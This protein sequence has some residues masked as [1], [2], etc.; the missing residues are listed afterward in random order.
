MNLNKLTKVELI[1]KIDQLKKEKLDIK[2]N[3]ANKIND[4][5]ITVDNKSTLIYDIFSKIKTLILSLSIIGILSQVFKNYK[6]IR[7]I[8]RAA[9]YIIIGLFGMSLFDAFG[10]GFIVKFLGELKYV[11]GSI[12]TYLT[13]STFYKYMLNMFNVAEE[14]EKESVRGTYKKSEKID[15]KAELEKAEREREREKWHA[16]YKKHNEEGIDK[17]TI[18]LLLLFLGGSIGVWY[19]GKDGL[20][21]IWGGQT[22]SSLISK[23]VRGWRPGDDDE[24]DDNNNYL[25]HYNKSVEKRDIELDPSVRSESP[26]MMETYASDMIHPKL[27]EHLPPVAPPMPPVASSSNVENT[28]IEEQPAQPRSLLESIK[29]GKSLKKTKIRE[30]S[31]DIR[32]GKEV[33]HKSNSLIDVMSTGLDKMRKAA[34]GDDDEEILNDAWNDDSETTPTQSTIIDKGKGKEIESPRS[35][36]AEL[37]IDENVKKQ[38]FLDSISMDDEKIIPTSKTAKISSDRDDGKI[39]SPS[40]IANIL[41]D[42]V[43]K[44]P[45]L[46]QETLEKLSTPEGL[47]NRVQIIESLSEDELKIDVQESKTDWKGTFDKA[48]ENPSDADLVAGKAKITQP[49]SYYISKEEQIARGI[50][51]K[52]IRKLP[53]VK[54]MSSMSKEETTKMD[55]IVKNSLNL[56]AESVIKKLTTEIPGVNFNVDSYKESFM[57][58][59]EEEIESGKTEVDKARIRKQIQEVDLLELQN[60]GGTSNIRDIRNVI[61]ENYTHN[62]L[63]KEIKS[64]ASR[65]S[66]ERTDA[67]TTQ[68]DDTMNLFE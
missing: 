33:P 7:V 45:N 52:D 62:T 51:D 5:K 3:S 54:E 25:Y 60:T 42:T 30:S 48:K 4:K 36:K 1:N 49:F 27:E 14:K 9:N 53:T 24:P 47:R 41:A 50:E 59:M 13:D 43:K 10:L 46:S 19:Y 29:S 64:K 16:K 18:L 38:K 23:I 63:L 17:K 40:K 15:W 12:V 56:D 31:S 67:D 26:G 11:F 68:L 61:R 22:L 35:D 39:L 57:Q 37:G 65:T 20:D 44:F 66:L 21:L 32:L 28:V 55:K 6:T 58:A 34:I 2:N 8:L